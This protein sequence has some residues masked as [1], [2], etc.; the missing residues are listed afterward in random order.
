MMQRLHD[1]EQLARWRAAAGAARLGFVPTMGALHA[2]HA[3]LLA[4]ARAEC[5]LVLAS[6]F[7]NPLQFDDPA[8]FARYPRTAADD[9]ALLEEAGADAAYFPSPEDMYG[10]G[11][12]TRVQPGPAAA[13]FEGAVRPGH[14]AGMLTVVLKLLL[15]ARPQR[16]YFGEKDAQPLFLVRQ[17]AADFELPVAIVPVATVRAADG[18]ALSSRNAR[19]SAPERAR[20]PVLYQALCAAAAAYRSG[21]RD[22]AALERHMQGQFAAAGVASDYAAIVDEA[23]FQ[24]PRAATGDW[25]AVT[26]ACIGA[27]RLI[28]NL[29]LR[30]C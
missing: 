16:A 20:A 17:M 6:V 28:D 5:E 4:R 9:A 11:Q 12:A 1:R 10:A 29:A 15:R 25:R 24:P 26:A 21:E 8:D 7:V 2:G 22:P 18:L 13:A 23:T 27:T 14:F 3:A 19:L 30:P